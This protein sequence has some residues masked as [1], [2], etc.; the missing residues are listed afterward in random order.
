MELEKLL[1]NG[2]I[3]GLYQENMSQTLNQQTF[4]TTEWTYKML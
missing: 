1:V 3:T 4:Q 2:K